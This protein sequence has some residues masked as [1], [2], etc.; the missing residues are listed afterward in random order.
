MW[1]G[2]LEA[3]WQRN[4]NVY[5]A[6]RE[7]PTMLD[8]DGSNAGGQFLR[9]SLALSILADTPV[10]VE[11]VRGDRPEPGLKH[12][13][14]A[15]VEA[16]GALSGASVAGA[17]LGATTVEF[18]PTDFEHRDLDVSVGTAGSLSLLF[19]ALLPLAAVVEDPVSVTATGG[20]EVDW[21]PPLSYLSTVKLPL[22]RRHG[23]SVAVERERT[24]FYPA[25][26]GRATL[27]LGPSSWESFD[28]T[29]R[30]TGYGVDVTSVAS[31]GLRDNDVAERQARTASTVLEDDGLSVRHETTTY[32]EA[33]SPGTAVLV[34]LR[35]GQTRAGFS[36]L[37]EPG[38]PAEDV[39]TAAAESA[40]DFHESTA[41]VVDPYM[42]DQ[43]LVFLA[44]AG[45]R[46]VIP[47]VTDHVETSRS[48]LEQFGVESTLEDREAG[49]ELS[50]T[51]PL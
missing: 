23:L 43:L 18:E 24:G 46:V 4:V 9:A 31:E 19:D 26:G 48:L 10:R 28:L 11:N 50:I 6:D 13:H 27:S 41:A 25:G 44:V 1:C 2:A 40:L 16:L 38:R 8:L 36:A 30:G 34:S 45:G 3:S 47:T 22:L 37:G 39:G 49:I 14:L 35:Y 12:Q 32:A 17:E 51:D 21:S 42:A 29:A 20:T 15:A 7:H 5:L 33:E